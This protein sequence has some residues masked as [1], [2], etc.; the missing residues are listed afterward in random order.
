MVCHTRRLAALRTHLSQPTTCAT[1]PAAD[2]QDRPDST[3]ASSLHGL[4]LAERYYFETQ[5]FLVIE[6]IVPP[7]LLAKLNCAVDACSHVIERT[8]AKLSGQGDVPA[9]QGDFGR[10]D[11]GELMEWPSP[12]CQPFR[13]LLSL[14]RMVRIMLDLIGP[15]FHHSSANGIVMDAGAE[16]Q[17]M[18]GGQRSDGSRG[19]R[20]AWTYSI[21]RNGH[22]ECNLINVMYQLTDIGPEDGGTLVVPGSHK[23]FFN[24]PPEVR[25]ITAA[26]DRFHDQTGGALLK[27]V[28]CKAGS[29]L[30][31]TEA[32]SHG[33]AP[34]RA[35]HQRRTMLCPHLQSY[36]AHLATRAPMILMSFV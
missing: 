9:L 4:S 34:W 13:D 11:T 19:R 30:I 20:D 2:H 28:P 17:T 25:D 21:D 32:L 31:F 5:G 23:A 7:Q 29:A 8:A 22:I 6:N 27:R 12:H 3:S 15:G 16:G 35:P 10:G 33:C 24:L 36:P 18:H 14:P 1:A 26:C